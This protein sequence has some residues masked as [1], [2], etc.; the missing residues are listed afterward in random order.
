MFMSPADAAT[1]DAPRRLM[2]SAS[3]LCLVPALALAIF[4]GWL[5]ARL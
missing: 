3:M 5:I 1:G 2:R 4:P